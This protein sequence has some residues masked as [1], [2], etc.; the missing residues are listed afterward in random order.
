MTINATL[1]EYGAQ[2]LGIS[3]KKGL[4]QG[5]DIW[6]VEVVLSSGNHQVTY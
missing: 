4:L 2:Q 3:G 5:L 6:N 1:G